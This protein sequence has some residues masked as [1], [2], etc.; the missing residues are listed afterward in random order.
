MCQL[1]LSLWTLAVGRK[2]KW[3][4]LEAG[5]QQQG[6]FS[7][8]CKK[9]FFIT[10]KALVF[11]FLKHSLQRRVEF[12]LHLGPV[13][14]L[15][16]VKYSS[17]RFSIAVSF[18][19]KKIHRDFFICLR[20]HRPYLVVQVYELITCVQRANENAG[21][22]IS[23]VQFLINTDIY[24]NNMHTHKHIHTFLMS[25]IICDHKHCYTFVV[26]S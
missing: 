8:G 12:H 15:L 6:K 19:R 5:H 3:V 18:Q 4:S 25:I 13:P 14:E 9:N 17:R 24:T 16:F 11:V 2:C 1:K 23:V 7:Q 22:L 10:M 21:N 20:V 26:N